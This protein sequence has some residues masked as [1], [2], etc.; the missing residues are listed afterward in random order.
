MKN[1]VTSPFLLAHGSVVCLHIVR[2]L[3]EQ[4]FSWSQFVPDKDHTIGL[5]R[6]N[7]PLH[8]L[9]TLCTASVSQSHTSRAWRVYL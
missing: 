3:V 7:A 5:R 2:S 4:V 1:L 9:N 8:L 6:I